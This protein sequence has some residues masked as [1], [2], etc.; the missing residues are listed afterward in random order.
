M[1]TFLAP[2]SPV[3]CNVKLNTDRSYRFA[4]ANPLFLGVSI[5]TKQAPGLFQDIGL[6]L[7][8]VVR[9]IFPFACQSDKDEQRR[10]G[11]RLVGCLPPDLR[12][13][14]SPGAALYGR[15]AKSLLGAFR[16]DTS[17]PFGVPL[18]R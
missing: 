6:V 11:S 10:V 8:A 14:K 5:S 15:R 2:A 12:G 7:H 13:P 18:L 4:D 17:Q 9:H 1:N 16:Y 3:R